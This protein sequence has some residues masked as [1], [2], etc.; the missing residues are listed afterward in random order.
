MAKARL[1]EKEYDLNSERRQLRWSVEIVFRTPPAN[2]ATA[3]V[4]TLPTMTDGHIFA[5][6]RPERH[7]ERTS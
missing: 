2:E 5:V 7:I 1:V 6:A 3:K 4:Q